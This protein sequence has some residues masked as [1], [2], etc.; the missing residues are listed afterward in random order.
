MH[1]H[2]IRAVIDEHEDPIEFLAD[3]LHEVIYAIEVGD[4]TGIEEIIQDFYELAEL[5]EP[6]DDDNSS[7]G[8]VDEDDEF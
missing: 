7:R 5:R 2:E 1:R 3:L 4:F 6:G 8:Y